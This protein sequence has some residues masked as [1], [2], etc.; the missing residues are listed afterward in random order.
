MSYAFVLELEKDTKAAKKLDGYTESLKYLQTRINRYLEDKGNQIIN[1]ESSKVSSD[2]ILYFE[3]CCIRFPTNKKSKTL[4]AAIRAW[5]AIN[6]DPKAL[7]V[8]DP[9]TL[10]AALLEAIRPTPG[11]FIFK[12]DGDSDMLLPYLVTDIVYHSAKV[13]YDTYHPA[14]TVMTVC[15]V[16]PDN[17]KESARYTFHK[18]DLSGGG[19][20]IQRVLSDNGFVLE[21]EEL[22]ENYKN[23][24]ALYHKYRRLV[25]EQFFGEGYGLGAPSDT[26]SR[27]SSW[28]QDKV[29]LQV[30]GISSKL[31]VDEAK[32]ETTVNYVANQIPWEKK[33]LDKKLAKQKASLKR[34][35]AI[36]EDVDTDDVDDDDLYD[37]DFENDAVDEDTSQ[38]AAPIHPYVK[39]FNMSTHSFWYV[40]AS[41]L[42]PYVYTPEL[43]NKLVLPEDQK[44]LINILINSSSTVMEDI[45][46]GKSGGI[47]IL[48]SGAPG[49]G[50]TLTAEVYSEVVLRPLYVVQSSQLGIDAE[51]LEKNLGLILAR[52][53]RW[54]AILQIDECD[55]YLHERGKDLMQNAVVGVFLRLLEYYKGIL[56]LTTNRETLIDDAIISRATAWVRYKKPEQD[57]LKQIWAILMEQFEVTISDSDMTKVLT[58][59]NSISGRDVKNILKLARALAIGA[60]SKE[61]KP[62]LTFE[63]IKYAAVF[64]GL[65]EAI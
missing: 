4:K 28:S 21:S 29:A 35:K 50:K 61:K 65:T 56:F 55:V 48:A 62:Q 30:D 26:E 46:K 32:K 47:I 8:K 44:N 10:Q 53:A 22:V 9:K 63:D 58:V 7:K 23:D 43:K 19:R 38:L 17:N 16:G 33:S 5:K 13:I 54:N 11:H 6:E 25:G 37:D 59:Y 40:H 27:Y 12:K 42:T 31:V 36:G 49:T 45:I 51:E 41:C 24:L 64:Q 57:Y 15:W 1:F 2:V 52:A 34:R 18:R 39:V 60:G 3:S 14:C 20:T